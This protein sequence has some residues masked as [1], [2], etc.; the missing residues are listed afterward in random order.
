VGAAGI[1]SGT[2]VDA[3]LE[4]CRVG[5]G[6]GVGRGAG[7]AEEAGADAAGWLAGR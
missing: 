2:K 7:L 3:P 4:G 1:G 6:T 5:A